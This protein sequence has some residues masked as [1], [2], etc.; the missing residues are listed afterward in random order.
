M[1]T[2]QIK[3]WNMM[4]FGD[5]KPKDIR[6]YFTNYLYEDIKEF[7]L[8]CTGNICDDK[9]I[10]MPNQKHNWYCYDKMDDQAF[11]TF[12]YIPSI[13]SFFVVNQEDHDFQVHIGWETE[14]QSPYMTVIN[15]Y[16]DD[17]IFGII[18]TGDNNAK[19]IAS[20]FVEIF[21]SVVLIL[22]RHRYRKS[23]WLTGIENDFHS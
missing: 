7:G 11:M 12:K 14:S 9:V 13:K 17:D 15:R 20:H 3:S 21:Q 22:Y 8:T 18:F 23:K 16:D 4:R 19:Y 6:K 1:N 2:Q 10:L 5:R